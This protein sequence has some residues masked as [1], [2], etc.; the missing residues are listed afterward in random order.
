MVRWYWKRWVWSVVAGSTA[1][2]G[3]S[4]AQPGGTDAPPAVPRV[5]DVITLKFRDGPDR[6]VKVLKTERQPDGSYHSEVKDTKTGE[7]FTLVD[8]PG[9]ALPPPAGAAGK[10][11]APAASKP[12]EQPKAKTSPNDP[13]IPPL[14]KIFRDRDKDTSKDGRTTTA[15]PTVPTP[16][17]EPEKPG[18]LKRLFGKKQPT[19]PPAVTVPAS[20]AG[21]SKGNTGPAGSSS[22]PPVRP[23]PA[24]TAEP[25]LVQPSRPITPPTPV[26]PAPVA[27]PPAPASSA[28]A[29]LPLPTVPPATPTPLGG[30]PTI[31]LPPGGVS[32]AQPPGD[33]VP[34][35]AT[36]SPT[37]VAAPAAP[38]P[39]TPDPAPVRHPLLDP[40]GSPVASAL[41]RE[42]QPHVTALQTGTSPTQRIMAARALAGGRHGSSDTVKAVLLSAAAND[43]NPAVRVR[44]IEELVTLGYYDPQFMSLLHRASTDPSKEVREA[45]AAALKQMTPRK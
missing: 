9:D 4:A 14:G 27:I 1:M 32:T 13:L 2:I 22:P 16:E 23:T 40:T 7:T 30:L 25:P 15:K 34:T 31:P 42:I 5:G 38:A 41:V 33:V 18:L 43:P 37:P 35:R 39:S 11:S 6:Q 26:V 3:M 44:C 21:K 10:T 24:T 36:V 28:P 19:P 17:P 20:T 45:A 8:R 12:T 29:P